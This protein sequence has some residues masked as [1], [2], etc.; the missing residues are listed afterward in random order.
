MKPDPANTS[1]LKKFFN[2]NPELTT[3]ELASLANRSAST[4]RNWK[5][6]CGIK[7]GQA[8][9][10]S[11]REEIPFTR[12]PEYKKK[13]IERVDDPTDWDN[14]AWFRQQYEGNGYGIPT[15]ARMIGRS[16]ALVKG[17]LE[18]YGIQTRSHAEA[19]KSKNPCYKKEWLEDRYIKQRWSLAK[20]AEEAGVVPYTIYNWLIGFN[21]E[22]RDIYEAMAGDRNPFHGRTHSEETKERI[23]Q[24]ILAIRN[25]V[26]GNGSEKE[27]VGQGSK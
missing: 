24:K 25:N 9:W 1:T 4:I 11:K 16:I 3:Y 27:K 15:V 19:V 18:K 12:Q 21:F 7:A 13:E 26:S 8:G 2:E 20:C 17:R 6:K 23:R 22:I 10:G 5:R 14:E